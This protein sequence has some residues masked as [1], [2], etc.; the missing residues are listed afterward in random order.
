MVIF[1]ERFPLRLMFFS[2]S[3]L[4]FSALEDT[5]VEG[6]HIL[7]PDQVSNNNMII[8]ISSFCNFYVLT[9]FLCVNST[10]AFFL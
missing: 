10:N 3:R 8:I 6:R 5:S 9:H 2:F 1:F 4:Q 7:L